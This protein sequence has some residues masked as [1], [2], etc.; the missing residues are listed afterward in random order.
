MNQKEV[1]KLAEE[2]IGFQSCD[3][4]EVIQECIIDFFKDLFSIDY[5]YVVKSQYNYEPVSIK[6]MYRHK[7]DAYD[8]LA[9]LNNS[10]DYS[11]CDNWV[12]VHRII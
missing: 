5:V 4:D 7:E 3:L 9:K 8:H 10:E 12:D 2:R 1:L 6:A 11:D